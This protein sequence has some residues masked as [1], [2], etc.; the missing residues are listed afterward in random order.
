[1]NGRGVSPNVV[2]RGIEAAERAGLSPI[3]INAVIERGVNDHT[4]VDLATRFKGTGHIVRFIEFMDVGNL[5]AWERSRVVPS[6]ELA[7]RINAATPIEP[8]APNY[9][10]EVAERWRYVDGDGEIGF[11]S[12]V[13]QP[14]CGQCT[15]A[16]LSPEGSIYTCLFAEEGTDV[17]GPLRAGATDDELR[18]LIREIWTGRRDRYSELR[19]SLRDSGR[20][21]G[22]PSGRKVEMYHIG[23]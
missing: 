18:G 12:S 20:S 21:S 23:G 2:L 15:R 10:G 5:N 9:T 14:F 8:V 3:K 19:A 1:M 22:S 16:R 13:T 11:I 17:K 4:A 6:R 7:E